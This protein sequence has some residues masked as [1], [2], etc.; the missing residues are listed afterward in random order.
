MSVTL[1]ILVINDRTIHT[2]GSAQRRV[3]PGQNFEKGRFAGSVTSGDENQ[4]AS[5]KLE[6]DRLQGKR[7]GAEFI[8]V[9]EADTIAADGVEPECL[10]NPS[11]RVREP[12]FEDRIKTFLN[13]TD[14]SDGGVGFGHKRQISYHLAKGAKQKN[15]KTRQDRQLGHFGRSNAGQ[16]KNQRSQNDKKRGTHC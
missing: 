2:D 11:D 5:R 13:P 3:E 15:N 12:L 14:L 10:I 16:H 1:P 7:E 8:L 4:F 6:I 9:I